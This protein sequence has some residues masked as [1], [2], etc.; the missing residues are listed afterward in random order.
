MEKM[1]IGVFSSVRINFCRV[2]E[3]F[4]QSTEPHHQITDVT[5]IKWGDGRN[6]KRLIFAV[7]KNKD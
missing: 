3:L 2:K 4:D 5:V 1:N 6:F 7:A